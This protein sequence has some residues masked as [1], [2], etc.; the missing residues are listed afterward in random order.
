MPKGA[1]CVFWWY[2][3]FGWGQ[4]TKK[5]RGKNTENTTLEGSNLKNEPPKRI[6][7]HGHLTGWNGHKF[8]ARPPIWA[9]VSPDTD[10][11]KSEKHLQQKLTNEQQAYRGPIFKAQQTNNVNNNLTK[12]RMK[13]M[14]DPILKDQKKAHSARHVAL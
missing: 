7:L 2:P 11:I 1:V 10:P 13:K 9:W 3:I 12:R 5:K 6:L 4:G 14:G 8:P